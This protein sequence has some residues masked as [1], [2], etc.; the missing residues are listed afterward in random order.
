MFRRLIIIL[1]LASQNL[2]SSKLRTFLTVLGVIIG[3]AAVMIVMS[4]GTSAQALILDQVRGIGS[5]IIGILPGASE[6][7]GPPAQVFGI[8]TTTLR[9]NDLEALQNKRN[10]PHLEYASGYVLGNTTLKYKNKS[11]PVSYQAVSS[12]YLKVES[13]E[14]EKGRF[15][16]QEEDGK[17]SRVLV[18][19]YTRAEDLFGD[20]DP[21]GKV[22]KL[23]DLNFRVVGVMAQ[24]GS[25]SF[26]NPDK[27]VFVPLLT[28]QK[29]LSGI[30]YLNAVRA[31]VDKESNIETT[32]LDVKEL[33]RDRHDIKV[34]D[35]DDFSVKNAAA[36]LDTL[37]NVTD[38]LKYFLVTVAA[39]ALIVGGIG[40]MNIMLISLKQRIREIGLRKAL[41]A[42]NRDLVIQF[43]IESIFISVVGSVVGVILGAAV[44]YIVAI[45]IQNMG[46]NWPFILTFDSVLI[47]FLISVL[48]GIVFGIY[49]ARKAAKVSPTEALRYE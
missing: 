32:I 9:N 7:D 41:G 8:V 12:T 10:V 33:L 43:I 47:A 5:N 19:G 11:Y 48:L 45:V 22:V 36:A 26:S 2:L 23:G 29:Q 1:K 28:G 30:D 6:E 13:A 16:T 17:I 40:I 15:F 34:G 18:L 3:I 25:V 39:I 46:Y 49:P 21:I 31:T 37:T 38:A 35:P 27:D 20:K 42:L 14:I 44:T 24:R 4:I